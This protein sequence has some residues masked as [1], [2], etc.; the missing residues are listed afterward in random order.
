MKRLFF[1]PLVA[2]CLYTAPVLADDPPDPATEAGKIIDDATKEIDKDPGASISLMVELAKSGRWG[3]F[4]GVALLFVVWA[5]RKFFLKMINPNVLPWLTLGLALVA[6][7]AVGIGAGNV[8]W[9]IIVDLFSTGGAAALLW[10]ALFKHFLK[11]KT[12]ET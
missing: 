7:V 6:S 1:A 9:Q 11:P 2:L 5:F 10:S 4:V 12:E 8:W 3:P